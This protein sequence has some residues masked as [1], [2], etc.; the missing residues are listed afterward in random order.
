MKDEQIGCVPEKRRIQEKDSKHRLLRL[1]R[2]SLV[3]LL[4]L[5][6]PKVQLEQSR[7]RQRKSRKT[8]NEL[9]S[10]CSLRWWDTCRRTYS[11]KTNEQFRCSRDWLFQQRC[12]AENSNQCCQCDRQENK[13][14]LF[15]EKWKVE[16]ATAFVCVQLHSVVDAKAVRHPE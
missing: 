1:F 7:I 5:G 12:E 13:N 8:S 11:L 10:L 9:V 15:K 16:A 4:N 2:Q 14:G 3:C 6:L